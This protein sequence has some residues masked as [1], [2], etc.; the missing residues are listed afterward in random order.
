M[1]VKPITFVPLSLITKEHGTIAQRLQALC[2]E[3]REVNPHQEGH[4]PFVIGVNLEEFNELVRVGV[5][6]PYTDIGVVPRDKVY[7]MSVLPMEC[8]YAPNS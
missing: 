2:L 8:V 4:Y 3:L 1:G 6:E 5:L 7:G